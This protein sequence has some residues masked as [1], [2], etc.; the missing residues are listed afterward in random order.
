MAGA[1]TWV[2]VVLLRTAVWSSLAAGTNNIV[3]VGNTSVIQVSHDDGA[4]WGE[5]DL[6]TSL[7]S[8]PQV[9]FDGTAF[10]LS[11]ENGAYLRS[12]DGGATWVGHTGLLY[13]PSAMCVGGGKIVAIT[14]PGT[15]HGF[16]TSSDGLSWVTGTLPG[17]WN[18]SVLG[19]TYGNGKF[20]AVGG[21]DSAAGG[22]VTFTSPDGVAWTKH[23]QLGFNTQ[24]TSVAFGNG[25]FVA[26]NT[27]TTVSYSSDGVNWSQVTP[28]GFNASKGAVVFAD[29]E[30]FLTKQGLT[31]VY[32]SSDGVTWGADVGVLASAF[33]YWNVIGA[34]NASIIAVAQYE[35]SAFRA[36]YAA[37][38]PPPSQFWESF[39]KSYEVL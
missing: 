9:V 21:Y 33:N 15:G 3:V 26:V 4:T 28:A 30:F 6:V 17:T 27:A 31:N 10:I 20:V 12:T 38:P 35:A 24:R 36:V 37:P 34:S 18:G 23:V 22:T 29:G 19:I 7:G 13:T 39:Q 5:V 8:T 32:R 25:A 14:T 1:L 2:E 11:K 16:A